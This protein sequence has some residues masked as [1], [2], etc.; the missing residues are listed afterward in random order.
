[1]RVPAIS[2]GKMVSDP[3]SPGDHQEITWEI[4]L[5]G[6]VQGV[7]FRPF[8][9]RLAHHLQ[10]KGWVRN[11]DGIVVTQ[12][13]GCQA[14]VH[15]YLSAIFTQSPPLAKA[16]LE[17]IRRVPYNPDLITFKIDKS[18]ERGL[19]QLARLPPDLFVCDECLQEMRDPQARRYRYPFINCTQC[20]PR[21]TIIDQ[22]PYDR[23]YTSMADF[24]LCPACQAEYHNPLDRRFHAQPLACPD[25]GPVV[26]LHFPTQAVEHS[27]PEQSQ[28]E[29]ALQHTITALRQGY[30]LAVKGIGGYHLIVDALSEEA[31]QRLRNLKPRPSKPLAVM[32]PPLE[33]G[34]QDWL[35]RLVH[36][37]PTDL[38]WLTHPSRPIVLLPLQK[39]HPLAANIVPNLAEIG[40]MLPYSPLHHQLL[41]LLAK[42][43]VVT[44]ANL[45]GEPVLTQAKEVETRLQHLAQGFLHHNR[46]IRRPVEDPVYRMIAK[47]TVCLRTGRGT[48]PLE[49]QLPSKLPHPILAVGG[50]IKNTVALAWDRRLVLSPHIGSLDTPRGMAVF[51]QVIEDMQHLYQVKPLWVAHDK[52]PHY[53]ATRWATQESGL[54]PF[55]VD[56]HRAH[57]SAWWLEHQP[58][59]PALVFAWDG[60]GLGEDNTFWGGEALLGSPGQWVRVASFRPFPLLGGNRVAYEPWRSAAALAWT[61]GLEWNQCPEEA[62]LLHQAWKSE[63]SRFPISSSVGRLFDAA[64]AFIGLASKTTFEGEAPMQLEAILT[65]DPTPACRI[66]LPLDEDPKNSLIYADWKPLIPHLM[67]QKISQSDRALLFHETLA[68]TLLEQALLLRHR[69]GTS[70]IGL[71][72]GVFQNRWLTERILSL[73]SRQGFTPLIHQHCPPNDA[74]LPCGQILEVIKNQELRS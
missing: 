49:W 9:Y 24:P 57:A 61:A 68:H 17:E 50:E 73:L 21:Y 38:A 34:G 27:I 10:L 12:V 15:A 67:N 18:Q 72:G 51:R 58:K 6:S 46:P 37:T 33:H 44:S 16:K 14:Q 36:I 26:T 60:T 3:S 4:T 59:Q 66:Q 1:M 28:G 8:L 63:P 5:S 22:L 64:A 23:P 41:T 56:H 2:G 20:G 11:Q 55:T 29:E 7:G 48:A 74:G 39:G 62:A 42:P 31:V 45:Q 43:F 65:G 69:H 30:L 25:C 71:T 70:L 54:L 53:H 35:A 40:L 19:T 13:Q 47:K 52:H 32:I